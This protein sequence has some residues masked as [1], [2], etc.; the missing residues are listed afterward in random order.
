MKLFLA[1]IFYVDD[2]LT[3]KYDQI[4]L[5]TNNA[6]F[7]SQ[8]LPSYADIAMLQVPGLGSRDLC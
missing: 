4:V 6:Q 2:T 1:A 7:S 5:I 3:T 8:A